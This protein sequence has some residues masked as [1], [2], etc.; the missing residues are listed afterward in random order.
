MLR[1]GHLSVVASL[2]VGAGCGVETPAAG[3]DASNSGTPHSTDG[4][5]GD[6]SSGDTGGSGG[7]VGNAGGAEASSGGA[8]AGT[9][10]TSAG[11][12]ATGGAGF[13]T[14]IDCRVE[15]DGRTTLVFVNGC[16]EPLTFAGSNIEGGE[17]E[18]G[19][20]VCVDV[21]SDTEPLSSLR[22]WGWLGADPGAERHT[23]A[24]FTFNTDFYDF[25]WYDI[26]YVDAHNLPLRIEPVERPDCVTLSC[27][28]SL[29]ADCPAEGRYLDASG[30]VVSCVS[31]NRDDPESPVVRYFE[32]CDDAYAWSGD[33]QQGTDP[34]PMRACAG[35]DW[36]ITFCPAGVP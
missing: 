29:L 20:H 19:A 2:T 27:P 14:T 13:S 6:A 21:G 4:D 16:S 25:D 1:V 23:L 30:A 32:S 17:L 9:G 24:E 3:S 33:D 12:T 7:G 22:Y 5:A 34:S 15:G 36:D 31:P 10:G 11:A 18:P 26:S 8:P 35:E 28:E